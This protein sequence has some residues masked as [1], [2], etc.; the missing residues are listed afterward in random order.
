M[1]NKEI[2]SDIRTS[3][4]SVTHD[5]WIPALYIWWKLRSIAALFIKRE[6][7]DKRLFRYQDLFTPVRC[8]SL[9][10]T[11]LI[12]C[13]NISIPGCKKVMKS[14]EKLPDM[15]STRFGYLISV[16]SV[17][18]DKDYIQTTPKGYRY[19]KSR[20]FQDPRLR[21]FWIENG[22]LVVPDSTVEVVTLS[23]MFI[24]KADAKRLNSCCEDEEC[25]RLLDEEFVA[26]EHLIEDIKTATI[27]NLLGSYKQLVPD[28]MTNN[29][30]Q[31]KTN[32]TKI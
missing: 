7:D 19:I 16:M 2:I 11:S 29:N 3:L 10:E 31:E 22:Y 4:R 32:P 14:I 24:N 13:C 28:E 27:K 12:D 30:S 8:F 6:A 18:Y 26:P 21:Y 9:K 25:I 15:Y 5:E 20:E 17:D 23:A 1:K